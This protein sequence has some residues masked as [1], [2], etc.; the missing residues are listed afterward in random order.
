M[1]LVGDVPARL[2][3]T[4]CIPMSATQFS[5]E[6]TALS[7][8]LLVPPPMMKDSRGFFSEIFR[9]DVFAAHGIFLDIAQVNQSS[10]QKGVLRGLHFQ[11]DPPLGKLIRV[12]RGEA[13][14]AFVDIRKKSETLGKCLTYTL[15]AENK[16]ALYVPPGFAAGFYIPG[17]STDV[18]YYYTALYNPAG[19]SNIR[20]DDP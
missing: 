17:E 3:Y 6:A 5:M 20:W 9:R 1:V 19:E 14:M 2:R 13:F 11:W 10:S 7:G 8:L 15:S 16:K 12:I 4:V 18:E